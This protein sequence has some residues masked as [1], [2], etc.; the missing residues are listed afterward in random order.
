LDHRQF[1]SPFGGLLNSQAFKTR[2]LKHIVEHFIRHLG[3]L[4]RRIFHVGV[5]DQA[6]DHF[7]FGSTFLLAHEGLEEKI[8]HVSHGHIPKEAAE[9][10]KGLDGVMDELI[11]KELLNPGLSYTVDRFAR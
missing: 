8:G 9:E 2:G 6:R 4:R 10:L 1:A 5:L 7:G 11:E 3:Q